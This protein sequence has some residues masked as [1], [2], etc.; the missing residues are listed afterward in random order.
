MVQ[1]TFYLPFNWGEGAER[2]RRKKGL[3]IKATADW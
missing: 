3:G 2:G 1:M